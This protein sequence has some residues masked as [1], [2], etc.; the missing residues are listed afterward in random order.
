[1]KNETVLYENIKKRRQA[2]NMSQQALAEAVGYSGKSMVSQVEKGM[3]DLPSTMITKFAKA[4]DCTEAYLM[5][6]ESKDT[7]D[8][9]ALKELADKKLAIEEMEAS[10]FSH[11]QIASAIKLYEK[12]KNASPEVQ[13]I[14]ELALKS[15]QQ[16]P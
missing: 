13:A 11:E 4:L 15:A 9:Q 6:W 2:L 10:G 8:H 16:K 7:T 12:Y 1:M 5:G 14:V 3:I